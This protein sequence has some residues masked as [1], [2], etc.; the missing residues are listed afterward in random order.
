MTII[1]VL[2]NLVYV[3]TVE[4]NTNQNM[5]CDTNVLLLHEDSIQTKILLLT[6]TL[7]I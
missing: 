3:V 4:Q 1:R 2:Y 6:L 7:N 5:Y